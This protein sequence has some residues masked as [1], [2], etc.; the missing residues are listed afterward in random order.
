[1]AGRK[2]DIETSATFKMKQ[3]RH[4]TIPMSEVIWLMVKGRQGYKPF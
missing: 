3:G 1:M 4:R 2:L